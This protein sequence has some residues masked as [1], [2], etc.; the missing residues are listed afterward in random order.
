MINTKNILYFFNVISVLILYTSSIK[1]F[2]DVSKDYNGT[3]MI[4]GTFI[5]FSGFLLSFMLFNPKKVDKIININVSN[6]IH[7]LIFILQFFNSLFMF[8]LSNLVLILGCILLFISIFN[9]SYA[10]FYEEN[11]E[12]YYDTENNTVENIDDD[13]NS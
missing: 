3:Q 10:F 1:T 11:N 5:L 7:Y 13:I 6:K 12:N 8:T 2:V 9:I 4:T